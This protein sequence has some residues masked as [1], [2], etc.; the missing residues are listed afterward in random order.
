MRKKHKARCPNVTNRGRWEWGMDG[1]RTG[2][3]CM[4][5]ET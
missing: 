1:G 5:S 4:W 2:H 3:G